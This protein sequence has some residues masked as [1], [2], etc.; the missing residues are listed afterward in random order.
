MGEE[1]RGNDQMC[2]SVMAAE[3][4]IVNDQRPSW[5][6]RGGGHTVPFAVEERLLFNIFV[7]EGDYFVQL[8]GIQGNTTSWDA[9]GF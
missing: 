9:Y 5:Q 3:E 7:G 6:E 2:P 8:A 1:W 4:R